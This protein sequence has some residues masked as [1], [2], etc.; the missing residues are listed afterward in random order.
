MPD[1]N[2]QQEYD[3]VLGG[4][5]P[6]P[7]GSA[8]LGGIEGVKRL[9]AKVKQALQEGNPWRF[10]ECLRTLDGHSYWVPSFAISPDGQTLVIGNG[11]KTIKIWHLQTGELIRTIE[12]HSLSVKSIAISPDGQT[13]VSGSRDKTI[14]IWHLQTGE[15][16]RTLGGHSDEVNC[17]A[18][19]PDGQTLVSGSLVIGSRDKTI[20]IWHLQTGELIRTIAGHSSRS[21][22]ISPDGKTLVSGSDD[23]TIKIWH[24][25][26]GELKKTLEGH[27][28]KGHSS[29]VNCVAISPDGKTIVSGSGENPLCLF[30][31]WENGSGPLP[32]TVFDTTIKVWNLHT[33]ELIRTIEGHSSSI[34]SVAISPDGKTLVSGSWDETIKIWGVP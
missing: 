10:F 8:I 34:N 17:V 11:D 20:K 31:S 13:L 7:E 26:T 21:F 32:L 16:I 22:A 25:Q 2:Q 29:Y 23:H 27:S 24:L 30:G 5:T 19:S 14:K 12:G 9:L 18:I 6:I 3:A 15:L 28:L 1:P 33:G 4:Q